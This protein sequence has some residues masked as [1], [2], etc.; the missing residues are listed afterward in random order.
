MPPP[1]DAGVP[2]NQALARLRELT[3]VALS[4]P[5]SPWSAY[6]AEHHGGRGMPGTSLLPRGQRRT[7][8]LFLPCGRDVRSRGENRRRTSPGAVLRQYPAVPDKSWTRPCR[9]CCGSRPRRPAGCWRCCSTADS[10]GRTRRPTATCSVPP[11][12]GWPCVC[13]AAW[14]RT[15]TRP[16]LERL[17]T[18]L[19]ETVHL[20]RLEGSSVHFIDSL[21]SSAREGAAGDSAA[22]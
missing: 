19:G 13:C 7:V 5:A 6:V 1:G 15:G 18:D 11:S 20:G 16:V 22:P 8:V 4:G 17:H 9:C 3:A 12:T 2:Y 10:S 14:S 21:E